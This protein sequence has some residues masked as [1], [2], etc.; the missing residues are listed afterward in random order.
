[1]SPGESP[2]VNFVLG[3][4]IAFILTLAMWF[5]QGQAL[6]HQRDGLQ[7]VVNEQGAQL[8]TIHRKCDVDAVT[9]AAT[10]LPGTFLTRSAP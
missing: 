5:P 9:G 8:D 1:M 3:L 4:I 2:T 10:C 7:D 6:R